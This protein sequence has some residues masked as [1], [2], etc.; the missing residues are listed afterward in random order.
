MKRN[1]KRGLVF[2]IVLLGMVGGVG[3]REFLQGNRC[4][5]L[6]EETITG[7]LFVLCENL[8]IEGVVEG[9]VVGAAWRAQISGRI[10]GNAYLVGGET[11]IHGTVERSLHYVG[12]VLTLG[13]TGERT[14]TFGGLLGGTLLTDI[15][16]NATVTGNII[17]IGYELRVA[18]VIEGEVNFWGSAL[19]LLG[20]ITGD[21]Y[22]SVGDPASEGAQIR[23]LLLPFGFDVQLDRAGLVIAE[24]AVLTGGITYSGVARGTIDGVVTGETSYT[25]LLLALPTLDEPATLV[26]YGAALLREFSALLLVGVVSWFLMPNALQRPI[27]QLKSRPIS[28]FS[29]GMVAFIVSFPV[30]LILALMGV[31]VVALLLLFR[32]EGV[33]V[34]VGLAWGLA[35]TVFVGGF[36]LVAIYGARAVVAWA[37]GRFLLR[38]L[39]GTMSA[40]NLSL[41]G[42]VLGVGVIA[43]CVSLPI[44][45]WL[46]NALVLF[47]GLGAV[48]VVVGESVRTW[49]ENPVAPPAFTGYR[50]IIVARTTRH[51]AT[52]Q[53]AP[54]MPILAEQAQ[55][56]ENLPEGFRW[57]FFNDNP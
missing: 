21:V 11:A 57:D 49:R 43:V 4:H 53:E 16:E 15:H 5:V 44:V 23:T 30:V 13:G 2:V 20:Q 25:Q 36:Y 22:A 6:P 7:T 35:N 24:G 28:S 33:A 40:R 37:A 17:T 29:V 9:D 34:V 48:L 50:P 54:P 47:L 52:E 41:G 18:G 45:G 46:I 56:M 39:H 3:A 12:V 14:S 10:T 8:L 38:S 19:Q 27:L 1:I 42:M 31:G 32:L 26:V 51:T 55:G